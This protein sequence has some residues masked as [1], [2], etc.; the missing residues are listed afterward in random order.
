MKGGQPTKGSDWCKDFRKKKI[1]NRNVETIRMQLEA[2]PKVRER[3]R[4]S[5]K[6]KRETR[7]A[8]GQER[9]TKTTFMTKKKMFWQAG[10]KSNLKRG[11]KIRNMGYTIGD[12]PRKGHKGS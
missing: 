12:L 8:E 6:E 7:R 3:V 11:G 10:M 9:R 2:G 5:K 4:G 1:R